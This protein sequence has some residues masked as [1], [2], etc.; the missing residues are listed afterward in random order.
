M[1]KIYESM[2]LD[3][4]IPIPLYYQL[5]Q[6]MIQSIESGTLKEGELVPPEEE[7]C[8]L[9]EVSRPTIRQAFLELAREGYLNRVKA[10]G[11]FI[12]HP[13]ISG[14]FF[15]KIE[16]FNQEMTRKGLIPKTVVLSKEEIEVYP[17]ISSKLKNLGRDQR[18]IQIE[19][20]R[21][22]NDQP[23]VYVKT[24]LTADRFRSILQEDLVHQSL[25][26]ILEKKL[27]ISI[28][29]VSRQIHAV[30]A[31]SYVAE[32]LHVEEHTPLLYVSTV[33][34]DQSNEPIEYSLASYRSNLYEMNI[35]LYRSE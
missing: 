15:Q 2:K 33:A 11:T 18:A 23:I 30:A 35:D 26:E 6:Y 5:K 9:L 25:Y 14:E 20:L 1:N 32:H 22:A 3:R 29:R 24:F 10:K 27:G 16:S 12:T 31:D 7:L 19:R 21:F 34:Y 13:K 4:T 28:S 8:S 17:E